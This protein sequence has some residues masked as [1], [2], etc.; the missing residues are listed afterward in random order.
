MQKGFYFDQER[1]VGCQSCMLACKEWNDL[2]PKVLGQRGPRW[3]QVLVFEKGSFPDFSRRFLSRACL[4]CSR[5][6]CLAAC[7]AQAIVKRAEDGIVLVDRE[8]CIGCRECLSSCP[9]GVPQ[10]G[11]DGLMQKCNFCLERTSQG[12]KPICELSCV[13]QAIRSGSLEELQEI[14]TPR[15][16]RRLNRERKIFDL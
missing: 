16:A 12:L 11:E 6:P 3:R 7:P 14:A 15:A 5:P 2:P 13:G 10:F 4:H 1:C 8:K 9:F